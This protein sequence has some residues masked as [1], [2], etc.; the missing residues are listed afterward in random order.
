MWYSVALNSRDQTLTLTNR[1]DK[2]WKAN[3]TYKRG[4]SDLLEMDGTVDGHSTHMV[5]HLKDRWSV[6]AGE[7]GLSLDF[8]D[9][10]QP[11]MRLRLEFR[12]FGEAEVALGERGGQ[13][14]FYFGLFA[15]TGHRQFAD[16]QVTGAL[17]HLFLAER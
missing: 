5:L 17:Q 9:Y 10:V 7:P 15:V 11:V 2:N 16:Q 3:F 12:G 4:P 14:F 13:E 6:P 1:D 8:G